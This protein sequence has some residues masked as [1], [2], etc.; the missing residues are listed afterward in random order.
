MAV[1]FV[2][3]RNDSVLVS[4][5]HDRLS[6]DFCVCQSLHTMNSLLAVVVASADL[7]QL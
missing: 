4:A 1:V 2:S 5:N 7:E 3:V 6:S